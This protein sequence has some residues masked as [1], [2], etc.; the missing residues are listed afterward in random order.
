MGLT[1][2][3]LLIMSVTVF[4]ACFAFSIGPLKFVVASEIFP[5]NIR[6]KALTVSVMVMWWVADTIIGQLT[7]ILLKQPGGYLLL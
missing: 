6:A 7:P 1:S 3:I 5:T 2:G 4:L